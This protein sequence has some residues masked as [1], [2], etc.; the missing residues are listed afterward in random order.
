MKM[1]SVLIA[2]GLT[3]VAFAGDKETFKLIHVQDLSSLM[4]QKD[5]KVAIFDANNKETR[6]KDGVIPG[7]TLLTSSKDYDTAKVL[8]AA[9]DTN[10]V[11]YCA[12]KQ[13]TASHAAAKRATKAGYTN[14]AVLAD[15][16][17]G[18]VKAGQNTT[19][20]Q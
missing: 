17:Q 12:N 1:L 14:V 20:L 5:A 10:L 19:K 13:C 4:A 18:W 16:I 8:P 15:G 2:F 7:A 9:K 3:C 11:F 6:E